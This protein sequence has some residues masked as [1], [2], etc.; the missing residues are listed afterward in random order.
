MKRFN[1]YLPEEQIKQLEDLSVNSISVSEHIRL[2]IDLYIKALIKVTVSQSLSRKED[3][4]GR[5][6]KSSS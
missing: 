1:L 4:N 3:K 2:A 5:K 6:S